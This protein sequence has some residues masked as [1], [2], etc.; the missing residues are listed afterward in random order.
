[1]TELCFNLW[2]Y[3]TA[4]QTISGLSARAYLLDGDDEDKARVLSSLSRH[5]FKVV[6]VYSLPAGIIQHYG[7]IQ[8]LGVEAVFKDV[9]EK[10][11]GGL[12]RSVA[13]PDDK[14][15]YA[16]PLFDFGE[17]FVPAEIGDGFIKHR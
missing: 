17:G 11:K 8:Q 4:Q 13:F 3:L 9:F 10:I 16:T 12:P 5:D 7:I 2:Y 1:M 14:L 6:P 15:Y